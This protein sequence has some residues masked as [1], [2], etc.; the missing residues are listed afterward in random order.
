MQIY[1]ANLELLDY[2][3]FATVEKGKVYETG[4]FLHN[5]A[6]AYAFGLALTPYDHLVQEPRYQAELEPLNEAG[7]Y[8]TPAASVQVAYRL[9][10]WNTIKEG[11]DFPGKEPSIGYPDWGFARM[12]RPE[13]RFIFYL[14]VTDPARL[15]Q[16]PALRE[17]LAGHPVRIRLG[18]FPAKARVTLTAA[19]EVRERT[20]PFTVT[21]LLNWRDLSVE[22][23]TCDI[24]AMTLPTRLIYNARFAKDA[25]YEARF[26]EDKIC[27]PAGMRFLAKPLATQRRRRR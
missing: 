15:P 19:D 3:F 6:L 16:A 1:Q 5:Y 27:L 22:P 20:G 17:A 23:E 25:Y 4:N 26:S 12:L 11:Y 2:V 18:K 8:L 21:P 14:L 9:I 7:L 10:Q 24:L 13:S